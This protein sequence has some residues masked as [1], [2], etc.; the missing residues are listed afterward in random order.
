MPRLL[1][2]L[3]LL[4]IAPPSFASERAQSEIVNLVIAWRMDNRCNGVGFE[5][6]RSVERFMPYALGVLNREG[7][8]E[9][10]EAYAA[11]DTYGEAETWASM[12]AVMA[13]RGVAIEDTSALCRY[14]RQVAGNRRDSIGRWL[15][16]Q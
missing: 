3:A 12:K 11:L 6:N 10:E 16:A 2:C 14:G 8:F 4:A 5:R 13:A 7:R 1:V 9:L 15:E